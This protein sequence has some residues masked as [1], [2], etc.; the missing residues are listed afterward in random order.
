MS[1]SRP[2]TRRA[3]PTFTDQEALQFHAQGRPGKLEVVATKPMATQRDLSLAYSPG[4]AVPVLAIAED[5]ALAFDYT[6]KGNLVAVVSN[7]TAI[8]GLGNRGAL[9]SKPVMEGKAVLFKRFADIDAFDLEVGTEDPEAVINCVR[10]LGPTFG[11]INLE[12]IKAPECFIIEER[13]RELMDIPVFHDDQHGTAI[14]AAAGVINALHL[15]GRDIGE[16]KLVVNG[17]GAAGI[18]CIELLKAMGFSDRNVI[19]CDTK[20]VVYAGRTEGMNQWKSA[21]AVETSRRSLAEA[22]EGADIVFGLSVK[23]AFTPEMIRAMAAQPII[24]AMANPDPEIT[25][26]EVAR[27]RDDAIMATGR[28]DYPNQVNNVLGFPYIFRGALDVRATTINM[29]MKIAAAQALAALAREDVPDEVAAA[30][31]GARPRFGRDYIIPVPF[32]P[33]LIHTIPPAVAKAAMDTGV[34]RKPIPSMDA[35]RAQLSARRD[36]VAGTLNRIFERVRKFPKRVVF[37][38]GEEE[39]VIRAAISFV[40][41]GLGTAILVGREERVL[42]KAEAAGIDLAGRDHIEIHNA[43]KS[44]RNTVYAQFLYARMQ[45]KGMLFRDCQRLIN[46][47]RNHFAASMVA[48]GDADAMVTGATRNYSVALDDVRHVI[49]PKPGHRVIGVSLCLARG[50][51]VL[52]ADTA[53]HEMPSAQEIAGIAI[54]AAGVARR[55]GYEPRVAL[56]SFSTFGHP[57]AERAEKVQEAVKILDGM[58]VDFEYDGEMAADVALNR[59]VLAQYPFSRLKQPANVLVMPAFHSASISTK[60]LQELGG[61]QVLGPLIVGLDKPVQIVSLGA[62]D[63]DLVNMAALAAFNIGG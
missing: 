17:A 32:D 11:G 61:A 42:A 1:E 30:Y 16:A 56:L 41:Q 48:L 45:R 40:N 14:I 43:A 39:V 38:E 12:D 2:V 49:D 4:V 51:I 6:A 60:M 46:Q 57:K 33:R 53:I 10:Y 15:T 26:E 54:E 29:E 31:Q 25:A 27:V 35:Y 52:V 23:G 20:G 62:T 50:R 13:L 18:A 34:A 3:R 5:P 22:I 55:L 9:A 36:P 37:A 7:G 44:D 28:S 58:R 8:L 63:T 19:L 21:H 47:D 24:F 59:E